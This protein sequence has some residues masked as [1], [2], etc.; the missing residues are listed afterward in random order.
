M[1][2][3]RSAL[4]D[5]ALRQPALDDDAYRAAFDDSAD[6]VL[7]W[8]PESGTDGS[9]VDVVIRYANAAARDRWLGGSAGDE[10]VGRR[11]FAEWPSA[12]PL[13]F[14]AYE[15]VATSGDRVRVGLDGQPTTGRLGDVALIPVS[16]GFIH[17]SRGAAEPRETEDR[18][19]AS[20]EE[21]AA[22]LD[23]IPVGVYVSRATAH[24]A[25]ALEFISPAAGRLIGLDPD[26]VVRD[27]GLLR[28]IVHP[29]DLPGLDAANTAALASRGSFRWEGRYF[30]RGE[31]R[32][33]S[34]ASEP[35]PHPDGWL[36]RGVMADV[37]EQRR[38]EAALRES[39][40]RY[41]S[42]VEQIPVGVYVTRGHADGR[43]DFEYLSRVA[44]RILDVDVEAALMDPTVLARRMHPDDL[45][46]LVA[47]NVAAHALRSSFRFECRFFVRGEWRTVRLAS[48]PEPGTSGSPDDIAWRGIVEDVTEQRRALEALRLSEERHRLIAEQALD[49]VWT[50]APDGRLTSIS[51]AVE[52]LIGFTPDEAMARLPR[53]ILTPASAAES[54]AFF[55][56]M[57]ADVAARRQPA[58][59]RG[60]Q[61]YRCRDGS[62]VWCDVM[63]FPILAGDGSLVELLGVSRDLSGRKRHEAELV[64]ARDAAEAAAAALETV[65]RDLAEAQRLAHVG[66]FAWDAVVGVTAW[67]E[68]TYRIFGVERTATPL[69][70]EQLRA[71]VSPETLPP[72]EALNRRALEEGMPFEVEIDIT[73]PDGAHRRLLVHGEALRAPDGTVMGVRGT[74][75][76]ITE[77][78]RLEERL[79]EA[80]RH[81]AIGRL[82]GTVAHHLNNAL[83][84]IG[85]SAAL[86]GKSVPSDDPLGENL[87]VI[88]DAVVRA[89]A[90]TRQLQAYGRQ[91]TLQ[92]QTIDLAAHLAAAAPGLQRTLGDRFELRIEVAGDAPAV[93]ADPGQLDEALEAIVSNAG[94]AMDAGGTVTIS[95][96]GLDVS[97]AEA[98][99]HHDVA[100]GRFGVL[101]VADSGTGMT[102]EVLAELF[103]PFFTTKHPAGSVGLGLPMVKGFVSQS[104]GWVDVKSEV[105]RG[106]TF[107]VH[108][109]AAPGDGAALEPE[110]APERPGEPALVDDGGAGPADG[111]T[112]LFVEDEE[113]VRTILARLLRGSGFTVIEASRPAEALALGDDV[114]DGVDLVVTDVLMPGM[115]GGELARLLRGRRPS[116]PVV[117]VS[118]YAPDAAL[119]RQLREPGTAFMAKPFR[120]DD[121]TALVG[122]LLAGARR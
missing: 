64:A 70:F 25:P 38:A 103:E 78:R 59:Y 66:S 104:G 96:R 45:P 10:V 117:F 83:A 14:A 65:N 5:A 99:T 120:V 100:P 44:G 31:W 62:T 116:L 2:E 36:W 12:R 23:R 19:R 91:R 3:Q 107:T 4:E 81:E 61:E 68:E 98:A 8:A 29:D 111:A 43:F 46:G 42:L 28:A 121:L 1:A 118:G 73:R 47:A 37:T 108:L 41:A 56:A 86:M 101:A 34:L 105:G 40:A 90:L 72:F 51:P 113:V 17:I 35:E 88:R 67:S 114:L 106:S 92:P 52:G 77:R 110:R 49:V 7:V 53:E 60:E 11:L 6:A 32:Q 119:E 16:G 82:A 87:E 57:L 122:S 18:P 76:D 26:E 112:L 75:A 95:V 74:A 13:L 48:E 69:T 54:A 50:M 115:N 55:A 27:P 94:D 22:I 21:Y 85:A 79:A 58:P 20:R 93:V 109:P 89:G 84:A 30:V 97:T 39:E 15:R 71:I 9:L 24:G 102:P 80:R 33:M 63:A